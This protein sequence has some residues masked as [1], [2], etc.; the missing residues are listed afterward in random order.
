MPETTTQISFAKLE[1]GMEMPHLLDIQTRAFESLLQLDAA[2]HDREDVGLELTIGQD[3]RGFLAFQDV[4]TGFNTG[5]LKALHC[6]TVA[7]DSG[8]I[9]TVDPVP[10]TGYSN[11]VTIGIDGLPLIVHNNFDDMKAVHCTNTFCAPFFR[12]R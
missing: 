6:A 3:G 4:T 12:R 1:Q 9:T 8:T 2:A 7:C 10:N 11:A 5:R